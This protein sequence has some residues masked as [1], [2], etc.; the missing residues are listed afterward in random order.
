MRA[1]LEDRVRA[2]VREVADAVPVHAPDPRE[3]IRRAASRANTRGRGMSAGEPRGP[4]PAS[5]LGGRA[6][7]DRWTRRTWLGP[8]V[9]AAAVVAVVGLV[10]AGPALLTGPASPPGDAAG[11]PRVP[12]ALAGVSLL[13]ASVSDAP[14]G[15][16][17]LAYE[18]GDTAPRWL[19]TAQTIVLGVDGRTYRRVD[20]ARERGGPAEWGTWQ[21]APV[22]LS[23]DG[24]QLAVGSIGP[25]DSL[26]V[27]DLGTGRAR[28][29]SLPDGDVRVDVLAWAP[30]GGLLV[31]RTRPADDPTAAG[32]FLI[33]DPARGAT[34]PLSTVRPAASETTQPAAAFAPD[35]RRLAVQADADAQDPNLQ[36]ISVVDVDRANPN[37]VPAPR[38]IP[39][40]YGVR[41]VPNVA[42]S[43]DGRWL[44]GEDNAGQGKVE[45]SVVFVDATD[46]GARPPAPLSIP[47]PTVT[48]LG[49]RTATDLLLT[50]H[51]PADTPTIYEARLGGTPRGVVRTPDGWGGTTTTYRMQ[52]AA[53]LVPD[54]EFHA[55]ADPERGPWPW[56]WRW[57]VA[58]AAL[59]AAG[60][61]AVV[62]RSVRRRRRA[63][64]PA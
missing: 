10:A 19:N 45:T 56:W 12:T 37:G 26:A 34:V 6:R 51:G 13:T 4:G 1:D 64:S 50:E 40:R 14:P 7:R 32:E 49:W 38:R 20:L 21:D 53:G 48:V 62:G 27:V 42:W 18:Q 3:L 44:A 31:I 23:P 29:L 25:V 61:L 8:A 52:A 39:V 11:A 33:T 28:E 54:L 16:A 57:T 63:R 35:G 60:L 43:P 47:R 59:L 2:A 58:V 5:P 46:S 41:L 36:S 55:A 17:V 22:L 30:D 9:A 24:A 15:P